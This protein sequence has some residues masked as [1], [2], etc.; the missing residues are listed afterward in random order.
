MS[1]IKLSHLIPT[2]LLALALGGCGDRNDKAVF[3]SEGGHS[4]DWTLTHKTSARADLETCVECHG[5]NLDGGVAKVAC[6]QCHPASLAAVSKHP[7]AWGSYAYARHKKFVETSGT[8]TC[9]NAVCHGASLA[10]VAGSGPSCATTCHLGGTFQ[11]HPA[12]WT[13]LSSHKNYVKANA[14]GSTTCKTL[15][16]HGADGK[17]AFLSGPACDQCHSMK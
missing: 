13:Q 16:C 7:V 9:E 3:S 12:V 8:T 4:S 14:N 11:K 17:G 1:S 10:G 2:A 6:S 5:E 15:A